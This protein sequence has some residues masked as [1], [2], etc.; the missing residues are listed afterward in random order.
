[1]KRNGFAVNSS[2]F[3]CRFA[4]TNSNYRSVF[5]FSICLLTYFPTINILLLYLLCCCCFLF[6]VYEEMSVNNTKSFQSHFVLFQ[7][8]IYSLPVLQQHHYSTTVNTLV[9]GNCFFLC[10]W[11]TFLISFSFLA[12]A[13]FFTFAK[14]IV[15]YLIR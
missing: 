5:T 3:D 8:F 2:G 14:N 13:S 7:W 12:L 15:P 9:Q 11:S 1:M 10:L 6:F 4:R